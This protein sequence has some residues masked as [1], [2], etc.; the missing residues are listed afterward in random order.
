LLA[1]FWPET[2][3]EQASKPKYLHEHATDDPLTALNLIELEETRLIEILSNSFGAMRKGAD[4]S[5]LPAFYEAFK[6]LS[7]TIRDT[8]SDLSGRYLSTEAYEQLDKLLN[9]QHSLETACD[10]ENRLGD[11]LE[12][13]SQTSFGARFAEAAVE[14]LDA[15]LLTLMDV[16]KERSAEDF[17]LLEAITSEDGI[18]RVRKAYLA[19]ES[20]LDSADRMQLLSASNH[21][22]RL[23]W[24]FGEMG[25]TYFAMEDIQLPISDL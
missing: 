18:A 13:L 9:L 19:E 14:G 15:V 10:E 24:L 22:E 20:E 5:Q 17:R 2:L 21:C 16:A 12:A 7:G 11:K 3:E 23:I 6:T 4:R 1:R 8:I 25:R